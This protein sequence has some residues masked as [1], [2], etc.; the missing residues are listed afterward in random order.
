MQT[1]RQASL[2]LNNAPHIEF[3]R[4]RFNPAQ[5]KLIPAH[6]TLIREDEVADWDELHQRL[7][8]LGDIELALQFGVP[9]REANLVY[10]PV[11]GGTDKFDKLRAALLRA[12]TR[13]KQ[14]PHLTLIHPRNGICTDAIFEEILAA[15]SAFQATFTTAS[16]IE[17]TD[18]GPW[19]QFA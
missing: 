4:T 7:K 13:R 17:Q 1:R 3:V 10:L 14:N 11:V 5:A 16:L 9:K 6:V 8:D 12:T 18:G 19:V 15:V 2:Y